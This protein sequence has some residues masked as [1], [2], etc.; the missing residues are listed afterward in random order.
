ML[1]Y[2][3]AGEAEGALGRAMTWAEAAW[4][5][6]SVATPDYY[7]YCHHIVIFLVVYTLAPLPLAVL[8]LR[9]P[10]ILLPYKLQPRVRLKPAAFLR[11]YVRTVRVFLLA[12]GPVQ[13]LSYPAVKMVGIRTGLPLPSA[14]ETAAQMAVYLLLE[15]YLGYWVHRLLHTKWGYEKIHHVHHEFTAPVG[16]VGL[17]A[18]WSDVLIIGFPAF[19]GPA[20]VPCHMT[21]LW[22]WFVIRQLALIDAHDG[23]DFPLNPAKFIPFYGGAPHHDYHH[24]VGRKSQ[25]NFASVFTFCDYIYGTD[26]GYMFHKAS[27]AK[28][29]EMAQNSTGKRE[30]MNFIGGKQA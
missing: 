13:L 30:T 25:S 20:V 28:L 15:D 6:Y 19:V 26:K 12:M 10:A 2:A 24:R 17:Y 29:K 1:P 23:F 3:T 27:L 9:A 8:Q 22:L 5:R 14:G 21:T 16:Y 18:H 7:L 11:C 4:F